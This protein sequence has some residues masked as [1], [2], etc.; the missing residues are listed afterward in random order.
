MKKKLSYRD[1]LLELAYIYN[2]KE[3]QEY[4]KRRKN[5]TSGQI[6]LILKKNKI[7][8]PKEFKTNFF[9]E[10]FTKPI[11]KFKSNIKD[12]KEEKIRDKNRF[13]RRI[14]NYK[15][16][17]S[18]KV[19]HGISSLWKKLG[20]AGINVLNIFPKLG[21]AV[22]SFFGNIFTDVFN[23]IYNQQIDKRS[24]RNVILGFFVVAGITTAVIAGLNTYKK[25][26]FSESKVFTKKEDTKVKKEVKKNEPKIKKETALQKKRGEK[27]YSTS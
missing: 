8:I 24:A 10:N 1:K 23:S 11:S 27:N 18:R 20:N 17:T 2:V 25:F 26:D 14:E 13:F 3:I 22:T 6:E 5:L 7:I 15:Y 4:V 16:D 12:F 9:K 21:S 19:N